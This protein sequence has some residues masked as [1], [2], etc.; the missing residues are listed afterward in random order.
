V[1]DLPADAEQRVELVERYLRQAVPSLPGE[2]RLGPA[3]TAWLARIKLALCD[4]RL[5]EQR[6]EELRQGWLDHLEGLRPVEADAAEQ[7]LRSFATILAGLQPP[8]EVGA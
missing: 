8:E 5:D 4:E 2:P 3:T 6:R 1:S 7:R